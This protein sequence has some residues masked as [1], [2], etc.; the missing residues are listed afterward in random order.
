MKIKILAA[1]LMTGSFAFGAFPV[2]QNSVTCDVSTIS[3][4][5]DH[6]RW[7]WNGFDSQTNNFYFKNGSSW[8]NL[9]GYH[10]GFKIARM[11][12]TSQVSYI[13]ITNIGITASN[14]HFQISNT[15][16]PP[17]NTYYSEI[18]VWQ[19]TTTNLSR[20]I[21]QGKIQV[22]DSIYADDDSSFPWIHTTNLTQYL[23][24]ADAARIY[25]QTNILTTRG[26]VPYY[27]GTNWTRLA[28]GTNGQQ[29]KVSGGIPAWSTPGQAGLT[30]VSWVAGGSNYLYKSGRMVKA[31]GNTNYFGRGIINGLSN[32][33]VTLESETITNNIAG[34]DIT[35][36]K[37]GRQVT[38]NHADTSSQANINNSGGTVIQDIQLDGR[39]H[40][41]N[42]ASANMSLLY[43]PTNA[44]INA[45]LT[46]SVKR[47]GTAGMLGML[48]MGG[49][50]ISNCDQLIVLDGY[51][52]RLWGTS[53]GTTNELSVGAGQANMEGDQ[54]N[55]VSYPEAGAGEARSNVLQYINFWNF[56]HQIIANGIMSNCTW[57]GAWNGL[58]IN[59][60]QVTNKPNV[61]TNSDARIRNWP[62][63]TTRFATYLPAYYLNWGNS[64]NKT[65][66]GLNWDGNV[67]PSNKLA[68]VANAMKLDGS[69]LAAVR[70][71]TNTATLNLQLPAY[72]KNA[73]NA[74]GTFNLQLPAYYKNATNASGT[75]NLQ[76]PAYYKNATNSDDARL[77][78]GVDS[79]A[80]RN[81]PY[82]TNR[83]FEYDMPFVRTSAVYEVRWSPMH[84]GKA[85]TI[86]EINFKGDAPC[87][88]KVISQPTNSTWRNY[89]TNDA[90]TIT[91]NW[92]T[93]TTISDPSLAVGEL[94]GIK[95]EAGGTT[96]GFIRV[97]GIF[98]P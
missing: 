54:I 63:N 6:F 93:E 64:S 84:I 79:A 91:T 12:T 42:G 23:L 49:N 13:S 88:A 20:T 70:N 11:A 17:N 29:L 9:T 19:G 51:S 26:D 78:D 35:R 89:V 73:T 36:S 15:N 71:A 97:K 34:T 90:L 67:I 14:I 82:I 83:T 46:N 37:T 57:L 48:D 92:G 98:D 32:R 45:A 8:I 66:S 86:T 3:G 65:F 52:L 62:T 22:I 40:V 30:N 80:F 7:K 27:N 43:Q 5:F 50:S 56:R 28:V 81:D 55:F 10:A 4:D 77:L 85:R 58:D 96:N 59:W 87:T 75:F 24:I 16:I 2:H 68:T 25:V 69:T 61:Q 31:I 18:F 95:L 38:I 44:A 41:T 21:A 33:I 47:N 74:S 76:A 39:G 94:L 53:G 72:Y 1:L 60:G